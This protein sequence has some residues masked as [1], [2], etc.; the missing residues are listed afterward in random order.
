MFKSAEV[1]SLH[2][3]IASPPITNPC[4]M[5]IDMK[6]KNELVAAHADVA[7]ICKIIEADSLGYLSHEG[8]LKVCSQSLTE[9]GSNGENSEKG[10]RTLLILLMPLKLQKKVTTKNPP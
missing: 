1:K 6:T 9:N 8:L 4:Y 3:R 5:G 10:N 7:E 2:V